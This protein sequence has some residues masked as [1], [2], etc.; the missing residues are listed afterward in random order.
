MTVLIFFVLS[1]SFSDTNPAAPIVT[2]YFV[3]ATESTF[4]ICFAQLVSLLK[5]LQVSMILVVLIHWNSK[6]SF[7]DHFG[8]LTGHHWSLVFMG[9]EKYPHNGVLSLFANRAFSEGP[10]AWTH[11]DHT[12]YTVST[13]GGQGF[14]Q[15]LPVY[16]DHI[17]YPKLTD[18]G[19]A[20]FVHCKI[21]I[22]LTHQTQ[23]CN[24]GAEIPVAC[25]PLAYVQTQ[26]HHIDEKG[27]DAGV[28]YFEIQGQ[29]NTSGGLMELRFIIKEHLNTL[30]WHPNF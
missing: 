24:R 3:V 15:L 30:V 20:L 18:A 19:Y 22:Y 26:T 11:M 10:D 2:G 8:W 13:A 1:L 17:L 29:E 12:G 23:I 28:V 6:Q 5:L 4:T 16:V 21:S 25:F 14:L 9:S 27:H 7:L